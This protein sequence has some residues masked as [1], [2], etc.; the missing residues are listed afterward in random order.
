MHHK[1]APMAAYQ[2]TGGGLVLAGALSIS[3]LLQGY[4]AKFYCKDM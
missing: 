3:K 2:Q 1:A 4:L